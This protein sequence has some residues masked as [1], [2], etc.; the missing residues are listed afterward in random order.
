MHSHPDQIQE[1]RRKSL[2]KKDMTYRTLNSDRTSKIGNKRES[3]MIKFPQGKD[4]HLNLK[5][6]WHM[7]KT[8]YLLYILI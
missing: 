5:Y 3:V 6:W 4:M 2:T 7:T 1:N 8:I